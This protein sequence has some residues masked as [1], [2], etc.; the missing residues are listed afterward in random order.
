[1]AT[2]KKSK[3]KTPKKKVSKKV[4]T[5]VDLQVLHLQTLIKY[6]LRAMDGRSP[7]LDDIF[8]AQINRLLSQIEEVEQKQ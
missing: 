7:V 8:E 6:C 2:S 5:I 1:M 3:K 4:N